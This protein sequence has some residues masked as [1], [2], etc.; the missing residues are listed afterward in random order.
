[1]VPIPILLYYLLSY[2][3]WLPALVAL[4]FMFGERFIFLFEVFLSEV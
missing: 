3:P 2:D 4:A 1:M